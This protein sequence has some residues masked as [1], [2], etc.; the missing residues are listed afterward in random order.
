MSNLTRKQIKFLKFIKENPNLTE[1]QIRKKLPKTDLEMTLFR[2]VEKK[3]INSVSETPARILNPADKF[4]PS[5]CYYSISADG[6][7]FLDIHK[8]K[9]IAKFF[10][11]LRQLI[12]L[13]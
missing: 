8:D 1:E 7:D 6:K 12:K 11:I 2:L 5:D 13:P 9:C 3:Y 10:D 4:E